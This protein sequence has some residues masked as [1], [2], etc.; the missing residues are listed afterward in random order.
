MRADE[1]GDSSHQLVW[2]QCFK[3]RA[4]MASQPG[5]ADRQRLSDLRPRPR[6]HRP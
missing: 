3:L 4:G 2:W 6:Q 1:L 5:E